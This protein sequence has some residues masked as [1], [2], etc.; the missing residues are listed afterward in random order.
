[1]NLSSSMFLLCTRTKGGKRL[2]A[3]NCKINIEPLLQAKIPTSNYVHGG[4]NKNGQETQEQLNRHEFDLLV[5]FSQRMQVL[6]WG[7]TYLSLWTWPARAAAATESPWQQQQQ[8]RARALS[9]C[10]EKETGRCGESGRKEGGVNCEVQ[11][12][13]PHRASVSFLSA[14]TAISQPHRPTM[15]R[16]PFFF[17]FFLLFFSPLSEHLVS[18][19]AF[20]CHSG[21]CV[22]VQESPPPPHPPLGEAPPCPHANGFIFLSSPLRCCVG[23][24]LVLAKP[25]R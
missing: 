1:M 25:R 12:C 18:V 22:T 17:P 2:C 13:Q 20:V 23:L 8:R 6:G 11:C 15:R 3:R 16:D 4:N 19:A 7:L 24:L 5:P 9:P 10:S 21:A 14:S